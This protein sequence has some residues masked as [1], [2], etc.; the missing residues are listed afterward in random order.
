[1]DH[2]LANADNVR[3]YD[4]KKPIDSFQSDL[5]L[6]DAPGKTDSRIQIDIRLNQGE[7]IKDSIRRQHTSYLSHVRLD[8][9]CEERLSITNNPFTTAAQVLSRL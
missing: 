3:E 1:M 6:L 5:A 7:I 4:K 2:H 8:S 9:F